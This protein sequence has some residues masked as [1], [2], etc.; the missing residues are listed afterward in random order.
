MSDT[1]Q[2][3]VLKPVRGIRPGTVVSVRADDTLWA[4]KVAAGSA[5][6]LGVVD[7]VD[8]ADDDDAFGE[9]E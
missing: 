6:Y 8:V 5:A 3:V 9:E 4:S 1:R 2:V 7:D